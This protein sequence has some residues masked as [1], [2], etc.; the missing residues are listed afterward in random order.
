MRIALGQINPII[1]DFAGNAEKI[2]QMAAKAKNEGCDLIV[3][4][5]MSL[6]GYPPRDLLERRKFVPDSI[7]YWDTVA[8]SS[9]G[10]G[11]AFGA[12]STNEGSGKPFQNSAVFCSD[13]KVVALGHKMLL[14]SY[15]VF[16]EERH[17]EPGKSP[18]VVEFKGKRLGLTV[19]EDIWNVPD[20]I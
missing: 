7:R 6:A 2:R 5:E 9:K 1:G 16:D 4:P 17:F 10:I 11:I 14:P 8:E 19:C 18:A 3:F 15:D 13:G 20:Y 12:V